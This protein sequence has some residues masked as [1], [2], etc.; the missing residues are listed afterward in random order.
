MK[1][2][3]KI[4]FRST[5]DDD[6]TVNGQLTSC[7]LLNVKTITGVGCS[8]SPIWALLTV[9]KKK[10]KEDSKKRLSWTERINLIT[11]IVQAVQWV[12]TTFF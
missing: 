4:S 9:T 6:G 3:L 11:V 1:V 2:L 8:F 10:K 5:V 12:V 7:E